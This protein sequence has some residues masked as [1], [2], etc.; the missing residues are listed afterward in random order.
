LL[1]FMKEDPT[2]AEWF[3]ESGEPSRS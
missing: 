2:A 3:T 1:E